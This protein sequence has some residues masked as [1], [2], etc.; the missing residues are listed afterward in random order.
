M[1]DTRVDIKRV[2]KD[3]ASRWVARAH[4]D[5]RGLARFDPEG[6]AD[7]AAFVARARSSVTGHW[8]SSDPI[9]KAGT[10]TFVV[11]NA[12]VAMAVVDA[13]DSSPMSSIRVDAFTKR[14]D[15]GAVLF[16]QG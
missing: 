1:A 2:D 14:S 8:K 7:G 10:H 16:T 15:G 9:A 11:G 6:I 4:T 13:L 12:P 5:S 3:G